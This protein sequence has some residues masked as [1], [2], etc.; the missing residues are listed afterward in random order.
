MTQEMTAAEEF[1]LIV[2]ALP[3]RRPLKSSGQQQAAASAAPPLTF[4]KPSGEGM[5]QQSYRASHNG[6]SG[7]LPATVVAQPTT[8]GAPSTPAP[9]GYT[10]SVAAASSPHSND[11]SSQVVDACPSTTATGTAVPSA[12][13]M[14]KGQALAPAAAAQ[15]GC[16]V[17]RHSVT[18]GATSPKALDG[19]DASKR[20]RRRAKNTSSGSFTSVMPE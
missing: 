2:G 1:A 6:S 14:P 12:N 16:Q 18:K 3:L 8:E 13:T 10:D 15:H 11:A 5:I 9:V 17:G 7:I 19:H 20:G 4:M